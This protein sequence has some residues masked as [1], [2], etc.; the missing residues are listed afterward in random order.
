MPAPQ[1]QQMSAKDLNTLAATL[2]RGNAVEMKQQIYANTFDPRQNNVLNIIPRNVGLIKYF[3]VEL[4]ATLPNASG[5]TWTRT[6]FGPANLL[7]QIVF[8]DL[9]NNVRI[10]DA[11]WHV[12]LINSV[13]ERRIFGS[14]LVQGTG[15]DSPIGYG[16]NYNVISTQAPAGTNSSTITDGQTGIIKMVYKIPMAYSDND[17]RGAIYANVVNATMNLQLTINNAFVAATGADATLAGYSSAGTAS[18]ITSV[19]VIVT[20]VFMDQIPQ[21]K[22]GPI[23]PILDLSTIYELKNTTF[24]NITQNQDFPMQYS[25]FRDFLSTACIYFNGNGLTAGTDITYWALRSANFTN[26]FQY[27]VTL[28]ALFTRQI[29]G[30]DVPVGTYYFSSRQKPIATTQYGNMELVLN[31]STAGAGA[32]ILQGVEDFAI[33]N[34]LTQAGSLAGA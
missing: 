12:E 4:T 28:A 32:Y 17:Y 24:A 1:Q 8:N 5:S 23:L 29:I 26:I 9:N 34:T 7:S 13:K 25:N 16:S 6:G 27:D 15:E 20:Q 19:S 30:A 21:G 33:V 22:N 14:A 31:A 3:L 10:N 11:G 18:Q 2:I